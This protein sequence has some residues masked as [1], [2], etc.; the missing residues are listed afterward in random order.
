MILIFAITGFFMQVQAQDLKTAD[1]PMAVT[2]AFD[3]SYPSVETV[4]WNKSGNNF[5]A[6]YKEDTL[7][8]SVTYSSLGTL[9]ETNTEILNG[10]LPATVMDY[11]SENYKDYMVT[12]TYKIEDANGIVTYEAKIKGMDL[13]FDSTGKFV[14]SVKN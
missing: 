14:K 13:T 4:D 10:D 7:S 8:R 12:E 5:E 1:I 6:E 9:V 11:V 2:D 3:K